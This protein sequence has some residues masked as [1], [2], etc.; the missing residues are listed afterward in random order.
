MRTKNDGRAT[1]WDAHYSQLVG[2]LATTQ[3]LDPDLVRLLN[4]VLDAVVGEV[5]EKNTVLSQQVEVVTENVLDVVWSQEDISTSVSM[6]MSED[7][8]LKAYSQ[9]GSM[10]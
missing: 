5:E 6:L 8:R 4:S 7:Q 10:V 1:Q 2:S 9:S 3:L